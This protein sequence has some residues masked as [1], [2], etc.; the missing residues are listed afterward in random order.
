MV[1]PNGG[2]QETAPSVALPSVL[3]GPPINTLLP[4]AP[5]C[6]TPVSRVEAHSA[7]AGDACKA[8]HL[9][10]NLLWSSCQKVERREVSGRTSRRPMQ[11]M[12]SC[13]QQT[14][15]SQAGL[16]IVLFEKLTYTHLRRI[17]NDC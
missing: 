11:R 14:Q 4:L 12:L 2:P 15:A 17:E 3:A 13:H 6:S 16:C 10:S 5:A 1:L 8:I 7:I 9:I